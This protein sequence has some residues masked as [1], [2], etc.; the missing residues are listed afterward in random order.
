M[1]AVVLAVPASL[2]TIA[3][4]EG[5]PQL[6]ER[7][8]IPEVLRQQVCERSTYNYPGGSTPLSSAPVHADGSPT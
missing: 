3:S 5:R 8:L 4:W 6:L 2:R 1:L 7:T